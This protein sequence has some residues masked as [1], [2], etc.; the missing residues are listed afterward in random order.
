MA[1]VLS[2]SS[3]ST[4]TATIPSP[5]AL[6]PFQVRPSAGRKREA[7]FILGESPIQ[8]QVRFNRL[9]AEALHGESSS[10]LRNAELGRA[11]TRALL[12]FGI[13]QTREERRKNLSTT[14][15][16]METDRNSP[17]PQDESWESIQDYGNYLRET[18]DTFRSDTFTTSPT[19]ARRTEP[20]S[21]ENARLQASDLQAISPFDWLSWKNFQFNAEFGSLAPLTARE[22]RI[23]AQQSAKLI[24]WIKDSINDALF[25]GWGSLDQ[26]TDVQPLSEEARRHGESIESE[27]LVRILEGTNDPLSELQNPQVREL[28]WRP[29]P[30]GTRERLQTSFA[31]YLSQET[32]QSSPQRSELGVTS[33]EPS[34]SSSMGGSGEEDTHSVVSQDNHWRRTI[35]G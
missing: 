33:I 19:I 27:A 5:V 31:R 6:A 2:E 30:D 22:N 17:G 25:R 18:A 15:S 12:N 3:S 35:F 13:N 26:V 4:T 34:R 21:P 1:S 11:A 8:A 14:S 9:V 28:G 10:E 7:S 29:P 16:Q 32:P 20:A 23:H 24:E